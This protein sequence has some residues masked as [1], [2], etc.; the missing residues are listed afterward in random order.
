MSIWHD[1][2]RF[3]T[4]RTTDGHELFSIPLT[5][6]KE[7]MVGRE[8]PEPDCEPKYFKIYVGVKKT[9]QAKKPKKQAIKEK[10]YCPYCGFKN[11][12]NLFPTRDQVEWIKSM[13]FRDVSKTFDNMLRKTI[14][15]TNSRSRSGFFNVRLEYKSGRIPNIRNYAEKE[16]QRV[17]DCDQCGKKY[18]VYG[19][20]KFCPWCGMGNLKVHLKRSIEIIKSL[21][22]FQD[23]I[24]KKKGKESGYHLLG[25]CLEDC[26]S[27]F[28]GFMKLI[29]KQFLEKKY[30][31]LE[32]SNKIA[33]IHNSF[34]N[35]S[36]TRKIFKKELD[37]E[38]FSN[39]NKKEFDFMDF[40][41]AKRHVITHNLSLVDKKFKT[42]VN[43]WQASGQDINLKAIDITQLLNLIG[44]VIESLIK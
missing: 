32:C 1:L 30:D 29:Y 13:I 8:C 5:P 7:G 15:S 14:G 21:L 27:L 16:L 23:E 3:K 20:A 34:Q 26:V 24:I 18:A 41:F 17:V 25:N 33:K 10:L 12:I 2:N 40:Q 4:G 42:Q 37:I 31:K 43:T 28:E 39:I 11:H 36:K 35:L 19:I 6:D 9:N 44:K 38:V 22:E